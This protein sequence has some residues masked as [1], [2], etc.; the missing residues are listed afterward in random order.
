MTLKTELVMR[1]DSLGCEAMFASEATISKI[2]TFL[3]DALALGWTDPEAYQYCPTCSAP[4]PSASLTIGL[5][6]RCNRHD[7]L[8]EF[9]TVTDL[10]DIVCATCGNGEVPLDFKSDGDPPRCPD[11]KGP[12]WHSEARET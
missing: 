4:P 3:D 1:C 5:E 7:K 2:N 8:P 10:P 12:I 9:H 11:C 6:E